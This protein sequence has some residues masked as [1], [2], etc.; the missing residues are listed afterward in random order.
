M[1]FILSEVLI[2]TTPRKWISLKKNDVQIIRPRGGI[3][4]AEELLETSEIFQIWLIQIFK[5]Y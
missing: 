5:I 3:S 2:I 1:C 4:H